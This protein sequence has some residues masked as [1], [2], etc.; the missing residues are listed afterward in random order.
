MK[1]EVTVTDITEIIEDFSD[2][3]TSG[4]KRGVRKHF[5]R[6][7]LGMSMHLKQEERA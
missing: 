5:K 4:M 2:R 1:T 6:Y 3:M 7:L